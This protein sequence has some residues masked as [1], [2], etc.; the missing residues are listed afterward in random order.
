MLRTSPDASPSD[1]AE[2]A[3][4]FIMENVAPDDVVID[5][6]RRVALSAEFSTPVRDALAVAFHAIQDRFQAPPVPADQS[7]ETLIEEHK[8]LVEDAIIDALTN[9][10]P[11]PVEAPASPEVAEVVEAPT[12]APSKGKGKRRKSKA[13]A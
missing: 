12:P 11:A 5:L 13:A 1:A 8:E 6:V 4:G 3:L 7:A 2:M 9:P 10:A